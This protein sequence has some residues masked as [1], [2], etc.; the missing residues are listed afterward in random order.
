MNWVCLSTVFIIAVVLDIYIVR[1]RRRT[2]QLPRESQEVKNL[3][4]ASQ[5][6]LIKRAF[7]LDSL[8]KGWNKMHSKW[9]AN[10]F[11]RKHYT[12]FAELALIALWAIAVSWHYM[13]LNPRVWPVGNEFG[14]AIQANNIWTE[15]QKCGWCAMWNG[16]EQGGHPAFADVQGSMLHP[17][18]VVSTLIWGVVNGAKITFLISLWFAGLAQ[19]WIAR[20]FKL[21]IVPRMWSAGIAIAGGYLTGRMELGVVGVVL[22]TAMS[23]LMLAGVIHL[24]T[25]PGRRAAILLGIFIASA[26]LSGQGY[27]QVGLIGISPAILFLLL[28]EKKG[29]SS[30]WK[31][32]LLAIGLGLLLATPFLVPF[33]HFIPNF[34]KETDPAFTEAQ[35]LTFL[36]LNLVIDDVKYY[37]SDI[38]GKYPY[39]YEYNLYIGWIPVL[40]AIFG[41]NRGRSQDRKLF[42]FMGSCIVLVLL[43]ASAEI[44]KWLVGLW[45]AIAGVQHSPQIAG[46]AVPLIL[47]FSAY[48]LEQLLSLSRSWPKIYLGYSNFDSIPKWQLPLQWILYIP[49]IFSVISVYNFSQFWITTTYINDAVYSLL[50]ALKTNSLEWVEPPYGEHFWIQPAI[51]LGLKLSPGIMTWTWQNRELPIPVLYASREGIPSG[52]VKEVD[53]LNDITIYASQEEYAAVVHDQTQEPCQASGSGG[54]IMVECNAKEAGQLVVKENM[55]AGWYAWMDGKPA[56]LYKSQWLEMD[57]SSGKHTFIFRYLPW[58]VPLSLALFVLGIV[59]CIWLWS[60]PTHEQPV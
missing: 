29:F 6:E 46:L 48:G 39:P 50:S 19:W 32:Y 36:P 49:L 1:G 33:L 17:I 24:A 12:T 34:G 26:I 21:G 18:V 25:N 8:E 53:T 20:S 58:D 57:A 42:W 59:A 41:I 55:W 52:M 31:E 2:R 7:Y 44:L 47:G 13:D 4:R 3:K 30:I 27:M 10:I 45:P 37:Q 15:A 9:I 28:E 60:K 16:F 56:N 35:P 5:V 14:S 38:L 40:L 54:Q 22:S 43:I 51:E 23:S 11:L